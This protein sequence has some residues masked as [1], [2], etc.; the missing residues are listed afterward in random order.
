MLLVPSF[1]KN[2]VLPMLYPTRRQTL[3]SGLAASASLFTRS[4]K[5]GEAK[6]PLT[7][8]L[9]SDLYRID[10]D[11]LGRGGIARLA[12]VV[13]AERARAAERHGALICV[14]AG[15]ALSPSLLSSLDHGAHMIA[16]LNEVGID[17]FVPGNHEFDFGPEIYRQRMNEARFSIL[18]ANLREADGSPLPGHEDSLV[19]TIASR[20]IVLI[21]A[22]YD[23]TRAASRPG[24][25]QFAPTVSTI[26]E[27][28]S[29]ARAQ[30]ADFIAAIIHADR[31]TGSEIMKSGAVDLVLSGHNHD[32]HIDF[33]GRTAFMESAQDANYVTSVDVDLAASGGGTLWW[34]NFRIADTREILPDSS[35]QGEVDT[36]K[37]ALAKDLTATLMRTETPLDSRTQIVRSQECAIGN[38]FADA[39]RQA[40]GADIALLNGGG[41][42]G[43]RLYEAGS[44]LTLGNIV[45]ELPFENK[46][47]VLPVTG[48]TL[49]LAIENGLSQTGHPS[50][51]F[52]HLSGIHVL[53]DPA[54]PAGSRILEIRIGDAPLEPDQ[55]YRLAT[56]D[57]LAQGGDGY[58][59]LAASG[60]ISRDAGNRLISQDVAQ[61]L[62]DFGQVAPKVEGRLVLRLS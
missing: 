27:R 56:N 1:R 44:L 52:P 53:A 57:Y 58:F 36:L 42:R 32:L 62:K 9:V 41:I 35:M 38:L 47:L 31:K 30:G 7:F 25:L 11:T 4:V 48:R 28:A 24:D 60:T 19:L 54:R 33:D 21:G 20:T 61:A 37:A 14:H 51:R 23:A 40:T 59:M 5:A 18:A 17:V 12:T 6:I 26:I 13:K 34:P 3:L 39:I 43:N 55:S 10:A 8:L 49:Q 2:P 22:A 15:D 29:S 50:G 46:T 45:E 16:L